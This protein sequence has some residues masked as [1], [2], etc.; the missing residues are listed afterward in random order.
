MLLI[1][2]GYLVIQNQMG[3]PGWSSEDFNIEDTADIEFISIESVSQN[4]VLTRDGQTWIVDGQFSAGSEKVRGLLILLSRIKIAGTVQAE[5]YEEVGNALDLAGKKI[6]IADSKKVIRSFIVYHDTLYS[7]NTYMIHENGNAIYR[8]EV[9]GVKYR[10]LAVLFNTET[11]FWKSN[12]L[13]QYR[14][15]EIR[16]I[17]CFFPEHPEYSFQLVNDGITLP[18][19]LSYTDGT[20][21]GNINQD[22][23]QRYLSYYSRVTLAEYLNVSEVNF[24]DELRDDEPEVQFRLT[25]SNNNIIEIDSYT[26]YYYDSRGGVQV[27]MNEAFLWINQSEWARIEYIDLDPIVK[28][29]DY[30]ISD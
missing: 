5:L 11:A 26:A 19:I 17:Q 7:D 4:V 9:P 6:I 16:H 27:N 15:E 21:T 20:E 13:F 10:N 18:K 24:L 30:F 14:P 2:A 25:D 3:G 1:V 23:V 28:Q 12:I 8:V 29:I 22:L